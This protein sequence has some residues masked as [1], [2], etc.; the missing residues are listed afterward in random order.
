MRILVL[1]D[2]LHKYLA[3]VVESYAR[4]GIDPEEGQ[5]LFY[6]HKAIG[7]ARLIPDDQVAKVGV[8]D[9]GNATLSVESKNGETVEGGK[10]PVGVT[11][12]D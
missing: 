4:R 10:P 8:N 1:Q 5:S 12:V 3:F 11:E 6:L 9:S 7:A 2:D